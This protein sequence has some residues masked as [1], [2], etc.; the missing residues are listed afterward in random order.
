ML[1]GSVGIDDVLGGRRGYKYVRSWGDTWNRLRNDLR[2]TGARPRISPKPTLYLEPVS[3]PCIDLRSSS[4]RARLRKTLNRPR[5]GFVPTPQPASPSI[6]TLDRPRIRVQT[7]PAS[8]PYRALPYRPWV[9]RGSIPDRT[10]NRSRAHTTDCNGEVVKKRSSGGE[11]ALSLNFRSATQLPPIARFGP[12]KGA[13]APC[14][15]N[16]KFR[17]PPLCIHTTFSPKKRHSWHVLS[18]KTV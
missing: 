17:R 6:E 18:P 3:R 16:N 5:A 13:W 7:N 15:P 4:S 12:A 14:D 1:G 9:H 10:S 8:T 2:S 11:L